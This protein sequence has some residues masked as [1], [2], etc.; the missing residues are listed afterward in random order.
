M[1]SWLVSWRAKRNWF[2][3]IEHALP[4][5][6]ESVLISLGFIAELLA[7]DSGN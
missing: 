4:P 2:A 5:P 7:A 6:G 1:D 3:I